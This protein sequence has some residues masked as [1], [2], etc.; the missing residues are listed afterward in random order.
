MFTQLDVRILNEC[1]KI[2]FSFEE[3]HFSDFELKLA[4]N[5]LSHPVLIILLILIY[6]KTFP[7]SDDGI[8]EL[9]LHFLIAHAL[10]ERVHHQIVGPITFRFSDP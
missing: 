5:D 8:V 4:P 2:S 1:S 10:N 6:I 9:P 7:Y 3:F